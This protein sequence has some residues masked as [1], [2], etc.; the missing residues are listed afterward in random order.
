M[1]LVGSLSDIMG[2]R[3][4]LIGSQSIGF[5]GGILAAKAESVNWLIG[6]QAIIGIAGSCHDLYP[7]LALEILPNKYRGYGQAA[8]TAATMATL[9]L[10]PLFAR[11]FVQ[12]TS[13]GWR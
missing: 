5:I 6:A 8:V 13:E 12:Y 10:G 7:P 3:Y 9:G 11:M 2:R 1:L 4:F